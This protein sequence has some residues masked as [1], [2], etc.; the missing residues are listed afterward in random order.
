LIATRL[1]LVCARM[2]QREGP[3]EALSGLRILPFE[4]EFMCVAPPH[5]ARVLLGIVVAFKCGHSI[6]VALADVYQLHIKILGMR[7]AL[8]LR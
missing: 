6:V 8:Y 3:R 4:V 1:I 2:V 7:I 5:G